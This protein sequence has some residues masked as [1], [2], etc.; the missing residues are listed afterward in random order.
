MHWSDGEPAYVGGKSLNNGSSDDEDEDDD[1]DEDFYDEKYNAYKGI[2]DEDHNEVPDAASRKPNVDCATAG[3]FPYSNDCSK[4][5]ECIENSDEV[6]EDATWTVIQYEC[7]SELVFNP[8]NETCDFPEDIVPPRECP[9]ALSSNIKNKPTD[10]N[11]HTDAVDRDDDDGKLPATNGTNE[12]CPS[13]G[14]FVH[15]EDCSEYYQCIQSSDGTFSVVQFECPSGTIWHSSRTTCNP[16]KLAENSQE[17]RNLLINDD[18]EYE[19]EGDDHGMGPNV[20]LD[21]NDEIVDEPQNVLR[22][23]NKADDSDESE[24]A[25]NKP[26]TET[27]ESAESTEN[28]TANDETKENPDAFLPSKQITEESSLNENSGSSANDDVNTADLNSPF[29]GTF[30]DSSDCQKYIL[31][32][33]DFN[34]TLSCP[35]NEAFN[36]FLKECTSDWSNCPQTP[37]CTQDGQRLVDPNNNEYYFICSIRGY[38][39]LPLFEILRNRCAEYSIFNQSQQKCIP[40]STATAHRG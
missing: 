2:A 36:S 16:P 23:D 29:N 13:A 25:T 20:G 30:A 3:I 4:F 8:K 1:D 31:S 6:D 32:G 24:T 38:S 27:T 9:N 10:G 40:P 34:V 22:D 35:S 14:Y 17:C 7:L 33:D 26:K 21:L 39:P 19:R 12:I 18:N 11:Q 15:P 5:Y 37:K 28:S